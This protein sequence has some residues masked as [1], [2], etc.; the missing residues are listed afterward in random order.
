ML[1]NIVATT[2]FTEP[3]I[4]FQGE[5]YISANNSNYSPLLGA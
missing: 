1:K 2:F 5:M 4:P 3:Y